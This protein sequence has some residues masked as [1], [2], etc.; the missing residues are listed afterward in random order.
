DWLEL[1]FNTNAPAA[2]RLTVQDKEGH[3]I[4]RPLL[5]GTVTD[6]QVAEPDETLM[7]SPLAAFEMHVVTLD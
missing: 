2:G 3:A 7:M 5:L 1:V 6:D 4:D